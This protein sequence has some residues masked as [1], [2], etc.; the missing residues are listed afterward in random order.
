PL[1]IREAVQILAQVVEAIAAA[2][3]SGIVH[4]DIKPDNVLLMGR[5][6]LVADFGVAKAITEID[7]AARNTLT[8]IGVALGTPAYMAPEQAAAEP[9]I[10]HRVDIYAVGV[11]AYELLTGSLPFQGSGASML[12][13][14]IAESPPRL[15]SRRPT[16]PFALEDI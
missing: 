11:M 8:T 9:N 10:D 7:S 12:A 13:A 16:V 5:H 14:H 2:H 15:R 6:A 3:R 4:R 1:P